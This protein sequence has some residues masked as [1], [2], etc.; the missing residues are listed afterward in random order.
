MA[1]S[2]LFISLLLASLSA[3]LSGRDATDMVF[4]F[5]DVKPNTDLVWTPCYTNFTCARLVVPLDYA[6]PATGN[7]TIAYIKLPSPNQPTEDILFNPGGPGGSGVDTVLH[8][9]AE[10]VDKLGTGYNIIGFDPRGVNNSGPSLECFP[11]NPVGEQQFAADFQRPINSRSPESVARAFEIMGAWGDWCSDVHR[12]GS[13]KYAGTVAN[14][15]DMLNYVEKKATAEGKNADDAKLWYWGVSYG[16]VLGATYATLFPNRIGRLILD[17]VVDTD[18]FYKGNW[19]DLSQSDDAVMNFATTCHAAGADKCAFYSS[20]PHEIIARMRTIFEDLRRDPLYIADP[21][22]NPI[23]TLIT[24]EDLAFTLFNY[25][26]LPVLG[27]PVLATIFADLANRNASSLALSLQAQPP[28]ALN[29]GIL[30]ACIDSDKVPG[31]TNI[32]SLALWQEH[33]DEVNAESTWAGD[34]W[35]TVA[36]ICRTMDLE[37]PQSQKFLQPAGAKN[38]SFPIL[39]IG[40]T[41]DPITPATGARKVS[42]LFPGS[43]VLIQDS[44]GHTSLAASSKCTAQNVQAYLKGNLPVAN[45]TCEVESVPF[46]T[47]RRRT[48][49]IHKLQFS[50]L[51]HEPLL[52]L[53]TGIKVGVEAIPQLLNL[54]LCCFAQADRH[55]DAAGTDESFVQSLDVV[56]GEKDDAFFGA[57]DSV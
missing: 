47:A 39:F 4:S 52:R 55:V 35:A 5:D 23:P 6:D 31:A 50:S 3:A 44:V 8:N 15:N 21:A 20:T 53:P 11:N 42:S 40:N 19:G 29:Y 43:V 14:A 30:V 12:N 13:A 7:T 9:S 48:H 25:V 51:C 17:G 49:A 37:P 1:R 32:S 38:T 34:V 16:S 57:G 18:T 45:T 22:I 26:Y 46:L 56:S 27:F 24:Y 28:T 41:I 36:L 2:V 10:L 33:I 54:I